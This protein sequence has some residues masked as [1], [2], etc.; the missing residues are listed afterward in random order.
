MKPPPGDNDCMWLKKLRAYV[1]LCTD[2]GGER[3]TKSSV[4]KLFCSI[5]IL[6]PMPGL[7][8]GI[9]SSWLTKNCSK[10]SWH[11]KGYPVYYIWKPEILALDL[12]TICSLTAVALTWYYWCYKT[13]PEAD[14]L[15]QSNKK[16]IDQ[17]EH[18]DTYN[19]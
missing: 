1:Y 2:S 11:R 10:Q 6:F 8:L 9:V 15:I 3:K 13:I 17:N 19:E 12:T 14:N 4:R 18:I 16:D 7:F 5:E